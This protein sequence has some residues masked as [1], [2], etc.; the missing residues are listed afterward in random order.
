MTVLSQNLGWRKSNAPNPGGIGI[1]NPQILVNNDD[2][3]CKTIKE[4]LKA[5]AH[6]PTQAHKRSHSFFQEPAPI[7]PRDP[8]TQTQ[9]DGLGQMIQ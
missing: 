6:R 4:M 5:V 2:L 8:K 7:A 9:T 3:I 1:G